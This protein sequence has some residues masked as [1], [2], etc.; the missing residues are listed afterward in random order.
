MAIYPRISRDTHF[1]LLQPALHLGH[2][3]VTIPVLTALNLI[4]SGCPGQAGQTA[5][6]HVFSD[7]SRV[8][9]VPFH[10]AC[11]AATVSTALYVNT[12]C[13]TVLTDCK[14]LPM[15]G[16]ILNQALMMAIGQGHLTQE[17]DWP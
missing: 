1:D 14:A 3:Q 5:I 4:S 15:R 17:A 2:R 8:I 13:R 16:A 6:W 12:W 10:H 11:L 9:R 7:V